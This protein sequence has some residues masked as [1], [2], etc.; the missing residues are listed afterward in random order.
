MGLWK[1]HGG[2]GKWGPPTVR[3]LWPHFHWDEGTCHSWWASERWGFLWGNQVCSGAHSSQRM[4]CVGKAFLSQL[5]GTKLAMW[6][7]FHRWVAPPCLDAKP[8]GVDPSWVKLHKSLEDF[9]INVA[10]K[11]SHQLTQ[12][13]LLTIKPF[14]PARPPTCVP[15]A[16]TPWGTDPAL[17]LATGQRSLTCLKGAHSDSPLIKLGWPQSGVVLLEGWGK[18]GHHSPDAAN[19]AA[20][21]P[22]LPSR[23]HTSAFSLL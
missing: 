21:H 12:V 16:S 5:E 7:S 23:L 1:R 22:A 17:P 3:G 10:A 14:N 9:F 2:K 11:E 13:P 18:R 8:G 19:L 15:L 4:T 20:P 6:G